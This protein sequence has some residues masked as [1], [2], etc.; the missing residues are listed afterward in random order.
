MGNHPI[1]PGLRSALARGK[2]SVIFDIE[3]SGPIVNRERIRE[4]NPQIYNPT[5]LSVSLRGDST[6]ALQTVRRV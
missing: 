2:T 4:C 5:Q 6:L 1:K 3:C